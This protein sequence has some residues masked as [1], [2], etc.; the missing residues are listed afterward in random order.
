MC[1]CSS[2]SSLEKGAT[3]NRNKIDI[4]PTFLISFSQYWSQNT[5]SIKLLFNPN[6]I[7][8]DFK[9]V[10]QESLGADPLASPKTTLFFHQFWCL[11]PQ[12]VRSMDFWKNLKT[13]CQIASLSSGLIQGGDLKYYLSQD[14]G[15]SRQWKWLTVR[16]LDC[17]PLT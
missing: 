10:P 4:S 14:T 15:L 1:S 6:Y 16:K 12:G 11:K 9:T 5:Y 13:M 7:M 17:N 8:G 2:L 3:W